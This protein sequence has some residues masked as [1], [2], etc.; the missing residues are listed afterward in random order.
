MPMTD[1]KD[2]ALCAETDP[3][4]FFPGKGG[5]TALAKRVCAA[6]EVRAEC[7]QDALDRREPF[8]I[9]GGKSERERRRLG[10]LPNPVRQCPWHGSELSGGPVLFHCAAGHSV[11]A[12]DVQEAD[13]AAM[14]RRAAA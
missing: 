10:K 9:W 6:C 7:L 14:M 2:R 8:G 12:A 1:W 3:E 5:S 4:A 13:E 11:T